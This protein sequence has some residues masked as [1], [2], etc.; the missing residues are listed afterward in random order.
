[1]RERDN[2]SANAILD[3]ADSRHMPRVAVTKAPGAA[4][5]GAAAAAASM[6]VNMTISA[7]KGYKSSMGS[8]G[9]M[10]SDQVVDHVGQYFARQGWTTIASVP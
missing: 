10:T 2:Q 5:D 3:T 7:A 8:L 6:G 9:S 4:A 1:M